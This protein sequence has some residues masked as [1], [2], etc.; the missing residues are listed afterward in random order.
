MHRPYALAPCGHV[1]CYGCLVRWFTALQNHDE[2][3][4]GGQQQAAAAEGE[5]AS[6]GDD[7]GQILNNAPARHGMFIRRRKTCPICRAAVSARPVEM[8]EIKNMVSALVRSRLVDL[9]QG[10][11]TREVNNDQG[12]NANGNSNQNDPWRNIFRCLPAQHGLHVHVINQEEDNRD[13]LGFFDAE[14]GVY[15]CTDC[16][17][18]IWGGICSGC[19]RTYGAHLGEEVDDD[20]EAIPSD[21]DWPDWGVDPPDEIGIVDDM[22]DYDHESDD[23]WFEQQQEED[24]EEVGDSGE[25]GLGEALDRWAD[26]LADEYEEEVHVASLFDREIGIYRYVDEQDEEEEGYGT[27]G[28]DIEPAG[29]DSGDQE[30][31]HSEDPQENFASESESEPDLPTNHGLRRVLRSATRSRVLLDSDDEN[32]PIESD[33]DVAMPLGRRTRLR[34]E[35]SGQILWSVARLRPRTG[36]DQQDQLE[37]ESEYESPPPRRRFGQLGRGTRVSLRLQSAGSRIPM[38]DSDSD[39]YYSY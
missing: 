5:A 7:V 27:S 19:E 9:P 34:G 39:S 23:I 14:D 30:D 38:Q 26:G 18:E 33:S 35:T 3:F 10:P 28:N 2:A 37:E 24:G 8:W 22:P 11:S 21:L 12:A 17:Y 29:Y 15:R 16:Y 31:D 36:A 4:D 1:A 25:D 32:V 6:Y 20:D 13:Q